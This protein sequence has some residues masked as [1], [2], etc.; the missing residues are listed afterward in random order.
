MTYIERKALI[1][2]FDKISDHDVDVDEA[3]EL[4]ANF[5]A[6]DAAPV[7]HGQWIDVFDKEWGEGNKASCC[8]FES[9]GPSINH[10]G[11]CPNCGAKMDLED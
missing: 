11:Y 3:I 7:K 6:A 9:Y 8:G 1:K 2:E 5:P 4:I 10:Y